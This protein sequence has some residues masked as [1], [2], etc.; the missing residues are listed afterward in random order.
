[1]NSAWRLTTRRH[2]H[3]LGS[4]ARIRRCRGEQQAHRCDRSTVLDSVRSADW[5][6]PQATCVAGERVPGVL[7]SPDGAS[8]VVAYYRKTQRELYLLN[9][10]GTDPRRLTD[11]PIDEFDPAW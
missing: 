11:T 3:C 8:L 5:R 2:R 4:D 6:P 1:M 9:A 7:W 10:D